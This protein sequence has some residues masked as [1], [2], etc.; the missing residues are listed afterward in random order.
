M[1]SVDDV[2]QL[3]DVD[4]VVNIPE[5]DSSEENVTASDGLK[6]SIDEIDVKSVEK[7][8]ESLKDS[9]SEKKLFKRRFGKNRLDKSKTK[10]AKFVNPKEILS[11]EEIKLPVVES[12]NKPKTEKVKKYKKKGKKP[13]KSEAI[14]TAEVT[15]VIN[16]NLTNH[17]DSKVKPEIVEETSVIPDVNPTDTKKDDDNAEP[18]EKSEASK[19]NS[20][21]RRKSNNRYHNDR[22]MYMVPADQLPFVVPRNFNLG[23]DNDNYVAFSPKFI[24]VP[25]KGPL[26]VRSNYSNRNNVNYYGHNNR[27]H[28]NNFDNNI[29]PR[30]NYHKQQY[31]SEYR[32]NNPYYANNPFSKNDN[33]KSRDIK[34]ES[35]NKSENVSSENAKIESIEIE[36]I[37]GVTHVK[38]LTTISEPSC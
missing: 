13:V 4:T 8:Q 36:K 14:K 5:I 38:E 30:N 6:D 35:N 15:P 16:Q 1:I 33:K 17:E 22:R 11:V 3:E 34:K 25:Y 29:K 23:Y 24:H 19:K 32:S 26:S 18:S 2:K 12:D 9:S 28:G 20:T 37:D 21:N 7:N 10:T 27:R 31:Y